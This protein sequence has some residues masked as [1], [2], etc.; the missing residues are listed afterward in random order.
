MQTGI[1]HTGVGVAGIAIVAVFIGPA[2]Q[3]HLSLGA[4]ACI[5]FVD[6]ARI[7]VIALKI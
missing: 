7:A 4:S 5:A 6:G 2:A 3:G 1:V